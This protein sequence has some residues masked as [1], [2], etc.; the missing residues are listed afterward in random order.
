[1]GDPDVKQ[2]TFIKT[3]LIEIFNACCEGNLKNLNIEWKKK[4]A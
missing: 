1:M 3:D 4:K 2:F